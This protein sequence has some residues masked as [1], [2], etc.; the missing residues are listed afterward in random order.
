MGGWESQLLIWN[1]QNLLVMLMIFPCHLLTHSEVTKKMGGGVGDV[2]FVCKLTGGSLASQF[3]LN[4]FNCNNY[5][6]NYNSGS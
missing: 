1:S 3:G 4:N 2:F 5:L 6:K